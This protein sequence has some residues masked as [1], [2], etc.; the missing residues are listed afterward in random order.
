[1]YSDLGNR[2][3]YGVLGVR[4]NRLSGLTG[5]YVIPLNNDLQNSSDYVLHEIAITAN[6]R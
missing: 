1:M 6:W 5:N 3:Y 4:L 2:I